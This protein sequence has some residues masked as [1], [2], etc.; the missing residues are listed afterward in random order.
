MR[1]PAT[2]V[3]AA[4]SRRPAIKTR[5]PKPT[6]PGRAPAVHDP[7]AA[8]L[9]VA[10]VALAL[11]AIVLEL[12]GA[13]LMRARWWSVNAWGFLPPGAFVLALVAVAAGLLAAWRAGAPLER[14]LVRTLG[15]AT[16]L[17]G[18]AGTALAAAVAGLACWLLREGHVLLGDGSALVR[19]IPAGQAFHPDEPL[20][21]AIHRAFYLLAGP[22]FAGGSRTAAEVAHATIGL[23][24]ALCGAVFVPVAWALAGQFARGADAHGQGAASG[25]ERRAA[26]TTRAL[27][28]TVLVSQG[29]V[30]LFFGYVENY[31][32]LALA[33]AAYALAALRA[34]HGRVPLLVPAALLVLALALHLSAAV[35]APSFAVLVAHRL[36]DPRGRPAALRD[37]ALGAALFAGM[38]LLLA[39]L[40]HG[41]D[42]TAMLLALGRRTT[43]STTSYGFHPPTLGQFLQQQLLIGPLGLFLLAPA[44]LAALRLRQ[45]RDGRSLFLAALAP[46][47]VAASLIAGDS[48]LG[49]A[50][51]WDLLAPA[52]FVFT[53]VALGFATRAAWSGEGLR[54]WL[55]VLALASLFHTVP[56]IAVNASAERS[57]ER[58]K[59][60]P[61]GL[62]R[63][64]VLVADWYA[65]HGRED[66]ALEWYRRALDENPLQNHAH[67]QLGRIA[68]HR[69][70]YD[71]AAMAFR[72]ALRSRPTM[73]LYRFQ[74]VDALVRAHELPAARAE[75]DTLLALRP[76]VAGYRAASAMLWLG[77]GEADSA[78]AA[79]AE[80]ERLAPG[81]SL[82]PLLRDAIARGL[83]AAEMVREVW[84]RLVQY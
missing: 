70:R 6:A 22:L 54:R 62:G 38:H 77:L 28:F 24:S 49:V 59:T 55:F 45:W 65:A 26:R 7:A 33:L 17:P 2:N 64:Q 83:P 57:L 43:D 76:R 42:W 41:Y 29:Y 82:A 47:Y 80:A 5:I 23:S 39:R 13:T 48:N 35:V 21:L 4:R 11:G 72:D 46:G 37:L 52:G 58:T 12:V 18:W 51:N 79:L 61:L 31:T 9:R 40:G 32:F 67:S 20:A 73:A 36:L 81:D 56:W 69:G 19:N 15:G 1:R 53:L 74:L 68:L 78:T 27:L 71:I 10:G 14:G 3:V 34:L 75:L 84:P 25:P 66:E 8:G 44:A 30:Q 60:L 63:S 16:P 50:R